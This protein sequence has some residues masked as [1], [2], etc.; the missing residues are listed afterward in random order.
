MTFPGPVSVA[1]KQA[2]A[3]EQSPLD[4]ADQLNIVIHRFL[5]RH[6]AARFDL[7]PFARRQREFQMI[8][9]RVDE[10]GARPREFFQN[11][12]FAADQPRAQP[13]RESDVERD[14]R[15]R[16]QETITLH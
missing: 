1:R 13:L 6:D 5:E 8:A 9:A 2:L 11:E 4:A 15:L 14:T 10:R 7:Q 3:A 12:S 16:A